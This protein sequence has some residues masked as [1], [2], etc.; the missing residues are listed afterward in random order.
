VPNRVILLI[1]HSYDIIGHA[2]YCN[3]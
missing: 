2:Y 1:S 3:Q